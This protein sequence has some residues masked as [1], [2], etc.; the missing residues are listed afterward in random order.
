MALSLKLHTCEILYKHEKTVSCKKDD[1]V[2]AGPQELFISD[3][4]GTVCKILEELL[5]GMECNIH[6]NVFIS[7]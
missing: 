4:K 3:L 6:N 7:L 5:V 2:F 1:A